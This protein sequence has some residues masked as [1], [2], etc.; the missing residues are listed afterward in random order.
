[1]FDRFYRADPSR[2]RAT[3]GSGLGLAITR[4]LVEA[5]D[6]EVEAASTPGAGSAF[7]IRLPGT[8]PD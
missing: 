2:S 3:G 1:V 8:L 5:H 4:H 7:T 6:G